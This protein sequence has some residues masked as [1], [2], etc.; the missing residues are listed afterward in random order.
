MK[1][2]HPSDIMSLLTTS[3]PLQRYDFFVYFFMY[4]N[5]KWHFCFV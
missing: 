3:I 4:E 5:I 1:L 2:W